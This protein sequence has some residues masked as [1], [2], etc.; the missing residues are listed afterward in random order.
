MVHG[1]VQSICSDA[2]DDE[3]RGLIYSSR[4]QLNENRIRVGE[5]N[6]SLSPGMA[7]RAEIKTDRRRVIDYFLSPLQQYANESLAER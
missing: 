7:V 2:I 4:I 3:K 1:R 5:R 6:I